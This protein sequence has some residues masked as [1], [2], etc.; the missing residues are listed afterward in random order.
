MIHL[1]INRNGFIDS[2]KI[3]IKFLFQ[4]LCNEFNDKNEMG[5][6]VRYKTNVFNCVIS[7]NC[8]STYEI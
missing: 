7:R 4:T 3:L 6:F 5:K 1:M 8:E 2:K